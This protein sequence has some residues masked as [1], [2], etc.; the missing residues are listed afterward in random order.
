MAEEVGAAYVSV[1]P[2]LKG[3]SRSVRRQLTDEL[4]GFGKDDKEKVHI[5]TDLNRDSLRKDAAKATSDLEGL[6]ASAAKS[7]GQTFGSV[8]SGFIKL[9]LV[10]GAAAGVTQVLGGLVA[11]AVQASGILAA[12]PAVIAGGVVAFAA[13]AVGMSGV[14]DA[15]KA[16]AS[17]DVDK[18]NAALQSLAPSAQQFVLAIKNLTPAFSNLKLATQQALFK[19]LGASVQTLATTYLPALKSAFVG[20]AEAANTGIT[21]AVAALQTPRSQNDIAV[22]LSSAATAAKVLAQAMGPVVQAFVS[23]AAAGAPFLGQ[24]ANAAATGVASFAARIQELAQS[25]G[26]TAIIDQAIAVFKTLGSVIGDVLGV[27]KGIATAIAS[28]GSGS[29]LTSLLGTLNQVINSAKGQTG[30]QEFFTGIG[31]IAKALGPALTTVAQGLGVI[32]KIASNLVAA[33]SG[34]LNTLL[35]GLLQ[36]L[37][38]LEPAAAPVGKALGDILTSAAPLLPVLGQLVAGI[39]KPLAQVISQATQA[40]APFIQQLVN[41]L[42]PALPP[43]LSPSASSLLR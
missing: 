26:I 37:K 38:A 9:S 25:G 40:M 13:L 22:V 34:G 23:L 28:V 10:A 16:V 2:S 7:I 11:A 14:G 4:G 17:G 41:Q 6:F 35:N 18:L 15:L 8:L 27:V 19:D 39:L 21:A 30:L 29:G 5:Q 20:V 1:V 32:G 36:G 31:N 33:G 24:F 42:Q 3:F 12:F 43:L